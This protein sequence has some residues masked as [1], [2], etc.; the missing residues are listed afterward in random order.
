M[1]ASFLEDNTDIREIDFRNNDISSKGFET[2]FMAFNR[3]K[4][5]KKI[6][7]EW[8]FLGEGGQSGC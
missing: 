7:A 6:S 2:I 1:L 8:N 3:N 5:L 4:V